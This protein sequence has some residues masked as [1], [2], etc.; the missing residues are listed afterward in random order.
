MQ[1][2]PAEPPPSPPPPPGGRPSSLARNTV[3]QALPR[4]LGYLFSFASAP[5][6]LSGLGLRN[7]GVWALTGA[8]AQYG[9]LL[10]LGAG[11]SLARY[12]AAHHADRR[13]CGEYV[14]VGLASVVLLATCLG[15]L[16]ILGAAPLSHTLGHV[17]VS[18]MRIVLGSSVVLLCCSMLVSVIAAYPIG[19]RRMVAPNVGIAL[20]AAINF[21]AS[22]GAIAF[23]AGLRGY[24]LAN[25]GAGVVSV[26]VVA[27]IVIR[28]EGGL[29]FSRPQPQRARAFLRYSINNQLVRLMD[30]INY[31]TDK[32]VIA[33]SVGPAAAGAYELANRVAMAVRQIGIYATSAIDIELTA[34]AAGG[35]LDRVRARY[36]RFTSFSA[37]F[38]FPP[39]L[40]AMATAPLL[41]S[42]WLAHAPAQAEAVLVALSAAYLVAVSTGVGYGVAVAAGEPGLVAKTSIAT[43]VVNVILTACLAPVF[44]IWGV[45]AGTVVALTGGALVQVT[46]V[47]RRYGLPAS[48]YIQAVVPALR[49]YTLLALPVAAIS[50]T[51][52]IHSRGAAAVALVLLSAGYV[53]ACGLWAAREDRLPSAVVKR[54]PW[55][56]RA[57]S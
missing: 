38:G 29:P 28:V 40:L 39:V 33:F 35:G 23:G 43:A 41:L 2:Q 50:Y 45:L 21:I 13:L 11:I 9:A 26:I 49:A 42:A 52:V 17:S 54:F 30:L 4:L 27:A 46:A 31:Q 16:A 5:I 51:K 15:T 56:A 14:A 44:G 32:I 22:V 19:H 20:G 55:L 6:V 10:D 36:Q 34:L 37:T 12:I 8:L 18:D 1:S 53:G 25:A 57:R 47:H 7:F 3:A 24:A 48:A